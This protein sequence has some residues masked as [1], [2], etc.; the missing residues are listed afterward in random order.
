M[1]QSKDLNISPYYDDFDPNNNFYKVLFK[2]GYPVQARELTTL[3]SILQNKIESFGSHIFKEGSIVIPGAPTY[4]NQFNAVKLNSSQF[5]V[6][7]SLYVNDLEGKV[8]EGSVSGVTA[9]VDYIALPDNNEVEYITLYVKYIN[10]G[11][12][13]FSRDTFIDGESLI[14]QEN[15]VY[16][17]TTINAGTA[18]ATLISSDATAVG[19]AASVDE[20]VYFI[21]GTFVKVNKQ[22]I[23]LDHY[24]NSPSYRVGLTIFEEII[25][26]KE[27]PSLYDNAKGFS[28]YAAPGA[29]R[30][31][32]SLILSKKLISD[33]NDENFFEILRLDTGD[34]LK[35]ETKTNY[36]LIRDWIA[37]RT[38]EESGNYA[39]DDFDISVSNSLNNR[40][41][42]GG[43]YYS[44]QKTAED[45]TP[46]DDL[47]CVKVSGGEAYVK[48]YD[49]QTD[50][51]S[52]LDV[53]KPRDTEKV[54]ATNVDFEFGNE[55]VINNV[56]G[57]PKFREVVD[58]YDAVLDGSQAAVGNV[59][60]KARIYS[61]YPKET[62]YTGASNKWDLRLYD[63]QTYTNITVDVAVSNTEVPDTAFIKG[64]SSGA[65]G[66]AIAAGGG[67]T[68]I[69]LIQ[70]SGSF[71]LNEQISVNG[72]SISRS[73]DSITVYGAGDILSVKQDQLTVA[74][75]ADVS[76]DETPLANGIVEGQ[77]TNN[78]TIKSGKPFVGVKAGNIISF[79]TGQTT[80]NYAKVTSVSADALTLTVAAMGQNVDGVY[81]GSTVPNSPTG[82]TT[83]INLAVPNFI[84]KDGV[85]SGLYEVLPR[86]NI[87]AVDFSSSSLSLSGQIILSGSN[88]VSG[89]AA[90]VS[91]NDFKDAGNVAISSA[92][93]DTF[94]LS[95]YSVHYGTTT[96][97]TSGIATVSSSGFTL[98]DDGGGSVG[99]R[100]QF[101][102]LIDSDNN[103]VVNITA[104]KQGIQSKIKSYERSQIR[105]IIYSNTEKS[106]SGISTSINDGLTYNANAYGLRVQD[107]EISLNVP[108]VV[109]ILCVYESIGGAQPTFDT[110]SFTATA[111]VSA[112]AII[113][114][115]IVGQTSNA[116]ARVVTNNTSTPSSGG[117]NKL[118]IV[119]LNDGAF[120]KNEQVIFQESNITTNIEAINSA[121]IDGKYQNITQS[122][123]LD[124]GQKD[125][126]YDYSRIVRNSNSS[127]PSKR[128]LVVYDSYSVPAND[129]GDVFTVL[130]YDKNRYTS[131]IPDI[132][133]SDIRASDTL[134]FRPRVAVHTDVTTS[135]FV[136]ASRTTAFNSAPKFLLSANEGS[137]VGYEYYLGRIDKLYL[138]KYGVLQIV[139]GESSQSPIPPVTN[140]DSMEL[141]SLELPPY[142][143]DPRN[144]SINL[145]DNRRYTMRDIGELENR[146]E[147]LETVT[148]L[149]LLEVST[150]S[151]TIQDA[152][153]RNRF[154]SG[155]FVDDFSDNSFIDFNLSAIEV[156]SENNEIRPIIGSNSIKP[157]LMPATNIVDGEFDSG[158]NY[159]LL[160]S[161]VQK[162]GNAVTLKYQDKDWLEQVYATRVENVNPF[163][164]ISYNGV[165]ELTPSSDTWERTIRLPEKLINEEV[166]VR[167][168]RRS[169]RRRRRRWRTTTSV[170]TSV[171]SRDVILDT[172]AESYMRSRNTQ[173]SASSLKPNFRYY[174]FLDGNSDVDFIPKLIEIANSASL[175][176]YGSVGTFSVGETVKGYFNNKKVIEFRVAKSNHKTGAFNNPERTYRTNPYFPKELLQSE[177]TSSSKVLNVD[178]LSLSNE[179][180]GLYNGY[181]IQGTKLVGQTTGT[182]A[183]VK[184]LR[185]ISDQYGDLIG[186][187]FIRNP[188]VDPQPSV[189]IE[190]GTK[191]Y[192][193]TSSDTDATPLKGSKLIS[194]GSTE[195]R[196]TGVWIKRQIQTTTTVTTTI[197]RTRF[198]RRRRFDPLAQSFSVGGNVEAPDV[199]GDLTDDQHG[200]F[201]TAV[202]LF[203]GNKDS[204]NNT[205]TVDIRTVEL[206]TPTL[207]SVGPSVTLTP[208]DITTS[209]TGDI[210]TNVR[211]PEP[212]YLEPG[213]EYALVLLSPNS[214]EYEAWIAR[215]GE[216]V[217][218][219]QSLP[220]VSAVQYNQQWALGSLFKSQNGSVWT[221]SQYE[222][223]K[224]K[225]YK[226]DFTSDKGT[227]YFSNPTLSESNNYVDNLQQNSIITIPKTGW[228]GITTI[229]TGISTFSAGRRILGSTNNYVT[230]HISDT[231]SKVASVS[232]KANGS[233]YQTQSGTV[234]NTYS[235][236]GNGGD[237]LK[238]N[239]D[240]GGNGVV[241]VNSIVTP[242][243][244]FKAGDVVGI[245]TA[246]TNG[247]SG[248]NALITIDS[249][250]G[251]DRLYLTDIQGT[252]AT[253]GFTEDEAFRYYDDNGVIHTPVI[254]YRTNLQS[255]GTPFD[256]K[257]LQ[258]NQFDHGMY[259]KNNQLTLSGIEGNYV[260]TLITNNVSVTENSTISVGSTSQFLTF[261][262]TPVGVGSTGYVKLGE[263]IIG[264]ES[265]GTGTL[266]SLT[267][268]VDSTLQTSHESGDE[269]QKYELDGVS[270][271]RI[272]TNHDISDYD[273]DLDSYYIGISTSVK[274][275]NRS[276]DTSDGPELSFTNGGFYGGENAYATR[277]IQFENITPVIDVF[278][279]STVTAISGS[280][281][282]VSGTSVGGNEVSF[283]DQGY[284]TVQLNTPNALTTPRLICSKINENE[285]L[286]NIERN[287][288]LTLGVSLETQNSNVSP[289]I[290]LDTINTL[291]LNTNRIN[292]PVSNYPDSQLTK[293]SL[294]DQH[295]AVYVSTIVSLTKPADSLKVLLSA[296]RNSSSD[297]RV[298]YSLVR[299]DSNEV[300]QSFE[301]F[302]G[303]DNLN[304]GV[305]KDS[306]KNSGLPD[307]FVPSSLD[308]Q[309]LEYEFT[310]NSLGE[311]SGYQIKIVMSGTNQAYPVR[312]KELRTIATK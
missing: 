84:K 166:T 215:M 253:G 211:F 27:D 258:V 210:A 184:D 88:T 244:G 130:S 56:K 123:T 168:E 140:N 217:V 173:F 133:I 230:A 179:A 304:N 302:P 4:D 214:N 254:S 206:G 250:T 221:P 193:L 199:N 174:Q 171:V 194:S 28:N 280:V 67:S 247:N 87:S 60:G 245:V 13:D 151:L 312:I 143:Y 10:G 252:S 273:I 74:F 58:L 73:I 49:V 175:T 18:V 242:G 307:T 145:V 196:S 25:T 187:F 36:N 163:H 79:N 243:N 170:A 182:I 118:G 205:L 237:D 32:I 287:K 153:G 226:A 132:G 165:V 43:I 139:K 234:V 55:L 20:G 8:V 89:A 2:P 136:F 149:S 229:T 57:Q 201:V 7:I 311:F 159:E 269:L 29:N 208:D 101:T 99:S 111:N 156:D 305:V 296:Y 23:I 64:L 82:G 86:P 299:P 267:R 284:Q 289:I 147:T 122:F 260:P 112:D 66:Y 119:Y 65:S 51:V 75:T 129:S 278:T 181:V 255:D 125:Q 231:G 295:S 164:V 185:L 141:A 134:D 224:F 85:A 188:Y 161:N 200:V 6:D 233:D 128:L 17:N 63:V 288:S 197:T 238:L 150:E 291:Q 34:V 308:D 303:Y 300:D 48:G 16:G 95:R 158:T 45:N 126:Y 241:S 283:T 39:I 94:D 113:G 279:P 59:I 14:I 120:V 107:E 70:T 108:D 50:T 272:N 38:Y 24:N 172:G 102:G 71:L 186:S 105:D 228:V 223:L 52:I 178:V 155:F 248:A 148:T 62:V 219:L 41:G 40:L 259:A 282:T 31:K 104:K 183:Y 77:I 157:Q 92:F 115:N 47:M 144:I 256:G 225:L 190:T 209:T 35:I 137:L 54:S 91:V 1:A 167:I 127:V 274:G 19:S 207:Q 114:E 285:Y 222:D 110:L 281:R 198:R 246:D 5:G 276:S 251:L 293:S 297:F 78:N 192:K 138:S 142:L 12:Q 15:L 220:D 180:Q 117:S 83:L 189:L 11:S 202:D 195:Y 21:R 121:E 37:E 240:I 135:P 26:A 263:E 30:L 191:T 298:L 275:S 72:I 69:S 277:N 216:D 98:L 100:A 270:L 81:T 61:L 116:I 218:N 177:Y 96:V 212:I 310:A 261:E 33:K 146:I 264:Y 109:K 235:V 292:N 286:T 162:T 204:G 131:D 265:Y 42:N 290:Y 80:P 44:N 236:V 3:Q 262:G 46:S 266:E 152:S 124:K 90:T 106:G 306:T 169:R 76:L 227:A 203:F 309:F 97:V 9:T 68:T 93:F 257:H 154:K 22:T 103:T 176:N 271:R 53:E 160:D 239:I 294:Y 268:G 301:F 232:V 249:I 213:R